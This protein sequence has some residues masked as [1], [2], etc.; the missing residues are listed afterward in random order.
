MQQFLKAKC[1]CVT[2]D[3][4]LKKKH[5]SSITD[6]EKRQKSLQASHRQRE[7]IRES[8]NWIISLRLSLQILGNNNHNNI[9]NHNSY[10]NPLSIEL[11]IMHGKVLFFLVIAA[12]AAEIALIIF[13][14]FLSWEPT[15]RGHFAKPSNI[16]PSAELTRKPP[17]YPH[18]QHIP[19]NPQHSLEL[20]E[21]TWQ[22]V[23]YASAV[24]II[25][26][27]SKLE[28]YHHYSTIYIYTIKIWPSLFYASW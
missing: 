24:I 17:P 10:N 26:I 11:I 20:L 2:F 1:N 3:K 5:P 4:F 27:I 13:S 12:L 15:T 23:F 6:T 19:L 22:Q 8:H 21:W 14:L 9:N 28:K 18:P 25:Y 7:I 16:Y